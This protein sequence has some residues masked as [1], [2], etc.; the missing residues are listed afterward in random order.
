MGTTTHRIVL[1]AVALIAISGTAYPQAYPRKPV[2]IVTSEAGGNFDMV[3]RTL[4]QGISGPL[5]QQV[6]VDNRAGVIAI[7]TVAK[8]P[9][10]GYTLLLNGTSIWLSPFMRK[11]VSW[12]PVADFAP[13]TWAVTAPNVLV[14]HPSIPAKSV[15]ELV[16]LARSRPASL[17][18]G[19][20]TPG[21][22]IHLAGELFKVMAGVEIVRVSYRG[23]AVA[24]TSLMSGAIHMMFANAS[25]SIP[26]VRSG[27]LKALG[28]TSAEPSALLPGVPAIAADLPGYEFVSVTAV[29]APAKTPPEIIARV[30]EEMVRVLQRPEVKERLFNVG[31]EAKGGPPEELGAKVKAE[32]A[33]MGKVI[34]DAGISIEY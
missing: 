13:V 19:S 7:E 8:A 33:R 15:K 10:D 5:G 22:S 4:A 6:L 26:H 12:D 2:R 32:M 16:G 27:R 20:T 30:N 1:S 21:G 23:E 29:F 9:P 14:V 28:V 11:N 34:R 18:F 24:L 3:A 31:V 25:G 17:N